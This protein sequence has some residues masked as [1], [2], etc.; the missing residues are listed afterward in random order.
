V[1]PDAL[2]ARR[3]V[4]VLPALPYAQLPEAIAHW[5]AAWLPFCVSE[6][7]RGVN[8]LKAREYLAAGLPCISTPLPELAALP[9]VSVAASAK[10]V[11]HFLE[12]EVAADSEAKRLARRAAMLEHSWSARATSLRESLKDLELTAKD[13]FS[14]DSSA[15][16]AYQN[17]AAVPLRAPR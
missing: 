13:R 14:S 6:L 15:R 5:R 17:G 4:R 3:N 12:S 2:R 10:D 16:S 1:L 7:T 9:Q 11:V 8:P